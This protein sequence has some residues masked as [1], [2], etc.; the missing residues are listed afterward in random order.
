MKASGNILEIY[1]VQRC[2][3]KTAFLACGKHIVESFMNKNNFM[4][5]ILNRFWACLKEILTT[6]RVSGREKRRP[7][8]SPP[9]GGGEGQGVYWAVGGG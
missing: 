4:N 5:N 8:V 9:E 7:V 1:L 6:C 2:Y 3:G